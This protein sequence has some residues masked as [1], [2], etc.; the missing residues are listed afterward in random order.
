M[1]WPGRYRA[2]L[3]LSFDNLGEAAEIEIGARAPDDVGDHPSVS[4][5]LPAILGALASHE[6]RAT[7]FVEGL[8]A[9][10]HPTALTSISAAGHEVAYHAWRHEQ[11]AEMTPSAQSE[12][13][14]RGLFAFE[15]IGLE[16]VGM[17][18]PGGLLGPD[19]LG[20]ARPMG[21]RY[22]SPAGSGAGV[23][24]EEDFEIALLPFQWQHVDASSVLP[25]LGAVREQIAGSPDPVSPAELL[26]HL[27]R[28]VDRL[29]AEGGFAAFVL[30]PFMLEWLGEDRLDALLEHVAVARRRGLWVTTCEAVAEHILH[31]ADEFAGA[32]TLDT[33]T[34]AD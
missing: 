30:H 14:T 11:W 12:N 31:E 19:W 16:A 33:V 22:C 4:V 17:R 13:L 32:A 2:A 26:S 18:P 20:V 8:N 10:L 3:C 21:L 23:V 28:E 29:I 5:A 24:V 25:S 7:F 15:E 27:R 9:H 6:I 34:W 1:S